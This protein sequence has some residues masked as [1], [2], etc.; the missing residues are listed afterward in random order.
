MR[1]LGHEE[2]TLRWGEIA[3]EIEKSL[4]HGIYGS[5]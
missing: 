1:M 2:L 3:P 5:I 4:A